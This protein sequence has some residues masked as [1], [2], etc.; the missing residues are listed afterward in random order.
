[1]SASIVARFGAILF[2]KTLM[3]YPP[4]SRR[5]SDPGAAI[6]L[7]GAHPFAH[8]F[9]SHGGLRVTRLPFVAD[10]E[11]GRP[12][13]LRAHLNG[14][15]PQVHDLDG[16]PVLV[17]FSGPSTYV[18]P[19]WRAERTRAGTYDYEEVQV[20][21][22]VRVV[23]DID[24]F[25]ELI[26]DLSALIE[27]QYSD[28]GEYPVWQTSM[29]PQ[30]YIER[31]FLHVTPF[32]ID[33]DAVETISKLHQQFPVEDRKA[34]AEHLSHSGRDDARAIAEKMRKLTED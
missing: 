12:V 10:T 34:V 13:R 22:T 16:A 21:G 1:M 7:M 14:Q 6:A 2:L 23:N 30:G 31:L 19:H 28:V 20:R 26:N 9:T 4:L 25:I 32:V 27:P 11:N 15:N 24:F 17:A 3:D 5:V 33:I 29:A 8:P 18:S